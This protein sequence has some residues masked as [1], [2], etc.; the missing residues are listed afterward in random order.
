MFSE[1]GFTDRLKK[2]HPIRMLGQGMDLGQ[3]APW[4]FDVCFLTLL[5]VFRR[6]MND[7]VN[8]TKRDIISL[9]KSAYADLGRY[10]DREIINRTV[11]G[12]LYYRD[13]GLQRPFQ[14]D[15]YS[16][17]SRERENYH[18]WYL[19][20]D[21]EH[22]HWERGGETVYRLSEQSQ[23]MILIT[24][25][26]LE[27]FGLDIEQFY[28]L[29]LIKSGNFNKAQGSVTN[30]IARVRTLIRKERTYGNQILR[31]PQTI[32][33]ESYKKKQITEVEIKK[34][35]DDEQKVFD[36]M[37]SWKNR[38]DGFPEESRLEAFE[39]FE[40]LEI[41]RRL[42]DQLFKLVVDN[43]ALEMEIRV[44]YP[45]SFWKTSNIT[46]KKD[47]WGD[48]IVRYGLSCMDD[49]EKVISPLFAGVPPFVYPLDWAWG[50]QNIRR[51]SEKIKAPPD[52]EYEIPV[53]KT[54][55]DWEA[56]AR[57]WK[58]LM[59]DLMNEGS[60]T[61]DKIESSYPEWTKRQI[62]IEIFMMFALNTTVLR[63]DISSTD[64]RHKLFGFLCELSEDFRLLEGKS[65]VSQMP[66]HDEMIRL[67]HGDLT[68][69]TLVV[70]GQM[71]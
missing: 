66:D 57:D 59:E 27:E 49:L 69:Y 61:I 28:T 43:L 44:K 51:R 26:I 35:F 8:R 58:P 10:P 41:A 20:T 23:E 3:E 54:R 46:F 63:A 4:A 71:K 6:E 47:I 67:E 45:D 15:I 53:S 52:I 60:I 30:L 24:R 5:K 70:R 1:T 64:E 34:Q 19:V 38:L 16:E 56:L 40:K 22:S 17:D 65:L 42:H 33:L 50:E 32:F 62:N 48:L 55:I 9:C 2:M 14:V 11:E 13:P 29:Q 12:I 18:F 7:N 68:R 37:L 31:S 39:V 21:R 36:D 25:E